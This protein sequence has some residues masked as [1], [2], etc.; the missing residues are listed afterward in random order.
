M[1]TPMNLPTANE[2]DVREEIASPLLHFLGYKRGTANDIAREVPLVYA[3]EF[4]G[5]KKP[6]DPPLRGRA[7]YILSV[8]GAGRWVLETK[9]SCEEITTDAIEQAISYARHPDVSASYAVILN[10][11]RLVV[12]HTTQR[13][14]ELPR[15]DTQGSDPKLLAEVLSGTLSPAAIRRDC[16]PPIVDVRK[17]L[18]DGLRSRA[19]IQT[20][21]IRN[22]ECKWASSTLLPVQARMPMDE[23]CRRMTGMKIPISGGEVWRDEESRIRAKLAWSL[24]H[25]D[26]MKFAFDKRLLD[27]EYLALGN[28]ISND[29]ERPTSWDVVGEAQVEKGERIFDL[30]NWRSETMGAAMHTVYQGRALGYLSDYKFQGLF[31]AKHLTWPIVMPSFKIELETYGVLTAE[32]N[33]H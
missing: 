31:T 5:R 6:S 13:S 1:G 29:P 12:F 25:E 27:V 30:A 2:A 32:L 18:A 8:S 19:R 23:L 7:D 28:E 22:I 24:P 33:R 9:P 17:P 11:R 26:L 16:S 20:G 15:I 4:L 21:E 14:R 3:R 10:G